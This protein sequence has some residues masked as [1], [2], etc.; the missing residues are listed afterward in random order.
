MGAVCGQCHCG[1][2]GAWVLNDAEDGQR[3]SDKTGASGMRLK[4]APHRF[5]VRTVI[6]TRRSMRLSSHYGLPTTTS[7]GAVNGQ[8]F[9]PFL[10]NASHPHSPQLKFIFNN[11][12]TGQPSV[13]V[14]IIFR[15]H[16]I[17]FLSTFPGE[18]ANPTCKLQ[19]PTLERPSFYSISNSRS[20]S[21]IQAYF[22]E[23]QLF[24]FFLLPLRFP[25]KLSSP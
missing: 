22:P 5:V 25:E 24:G 4:S 23:Q 16:Q 20:D 3:A 11:K 13:A 12:A 10:L 2:R 9:L 17:I 1:A 14:D 19:P 7:H 15:C 6:C 21:I 8:G 18:D